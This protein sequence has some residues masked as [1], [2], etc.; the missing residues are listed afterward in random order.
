MVY[1]LEIFL[2]VTQH[3][4]LTYL[5]LEYKVIYILLCKRLSHK[6][7]VINLCFNLCRN[8]KILN[9]ILPLLLIVLFILKGGGGKLFLEPLSILS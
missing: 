1:N 4:T 8:D 7:L 9:T 5:Q 2:R 6:L 3:Q